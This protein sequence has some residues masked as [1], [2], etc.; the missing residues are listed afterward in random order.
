MPK[1]NTNNPDVRDYLITICEDWVRKYHVDGI[2]LDVANEISHVFCK[3]LRSRLKSINP[4]IYILGEIWHDSLP[5]LHGDEFDSVMNYPL[6]QSIKNYWI[7]PSQTNESLEHT[8]NLCY[9][10]YMQQTNDVL[11]NLLDSHDTKRLR[12]EV[13]TLDEFFQQLALLFAM[14]GT[15][16][17]YY[18]TE[19][20]MEGD[21]DPDCRRPMPWDEIEDGK[22]TE[23]I[24]LVKS[25]IALRKKEP[26]L[27]S[28]SFHFPNTFENPR[29]IEFRK[30][31]WCDNYI[32][33][34][35]NCSE[36]DL[37]L[38]PKGNVVFSRHYMDNILLK[39]G[40]LFR[41]IQ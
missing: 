1:L 34:I 7:D 39:N 31:N 21:Y 26:L 16:C 23:R 27:R 25:L 14:P 9:T 13:N 33:V 30:N 22:Y 17:I 15:P 18:G 4:D 11:F 8:I 38:E 28:N 37:E 35:I 32:E 3:E 20:A 6:A 41:R 5:W 24:A 40:I 29:V 10:R 19:I 2:R 36:E 12:S